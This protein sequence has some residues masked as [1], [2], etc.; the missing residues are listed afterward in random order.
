MGNNWRWPAGGAPIQ[1]F[2]F[3]F[4]HQRGAGA[5]PIG[6]IGQGDMAARAQIGTQVLFHELLARS[7]IFIALAISTPER[8]STGEGRRDCPGQRTWILKGES[9]DSF[10][11]RI[12]RP[13]HRGIHPGSAVGIQLQCFHTCCS[14]DYL[15]RS[16][17]T[18]GLVQNKGSA[19]SGALRQVRNSTGL[20][21]SFADRKIGRRVLMP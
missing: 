18:V 6:L 8:L 19:H 21:S 4:G 15:P 14:P 9:G 3:E 10:S 12:F 2:D 13:Q 11:P 1:H 20:S 16:P 17:R 5:A 7:S